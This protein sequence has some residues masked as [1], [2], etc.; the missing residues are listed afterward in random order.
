MTDTTTVWDTANARG[1]W[2]LSGAML[3]TGSDLQTAYL[4]SLFTDRV[5]QPG[6]VIPDG[7]ADARGWIGDAGATYPIG[8]R[9]WLLDRATK[10]QQTMNRARTYV[11]EAVQW[12][13]DDG[14]VSKHDITLAWVQGAP[15]TWGIGIWIQ[16]YRPDG[17]TFPQFNWVWGEFQ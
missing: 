5:A 13:L 2:T 7:T 4:I 10:S 6:D 3:Q 15:G 8:S 17:T 1:D 14:V 16:A 9:L 12:L 11:T